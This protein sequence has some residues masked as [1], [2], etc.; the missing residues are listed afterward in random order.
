MVSIE[1][2]G[3]YYAKLEVFKKI[4]LGRT[5]KSIA[6]VDSHQE[7]RDSFM[8]QF[9][10]ESFEIVQAGYFGCS[11]RME[12][13]KEFMSAHFYLCW[14]VSESHPIQKSRQIEHNIPRRIFINFPEYSSYDHR[15]TGSLLFRALVWA[16]FPACISDSGGAYIGPA[17]VDWPA[18]QW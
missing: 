2:I 16:G 8:R 12:N 9:C 15:H 14:V 7:H 3:I 18:R 4:V 10:F 1:Y 17:A 5:Y 6:V 13:R 11:F